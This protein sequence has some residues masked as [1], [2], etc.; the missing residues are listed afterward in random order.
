MK[1]LFRLLAWILGAMA[2][3]GFWQNYQMLMGRPVSP[4][5]TVM[6]RSHSYVAGMLTVPVVL[7]LMALGFG[8]LS[9]HRC[10]K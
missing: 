4:A 8:R 1:S 9:V 5:D 7:L 6:M 3:I 2:L 10:E